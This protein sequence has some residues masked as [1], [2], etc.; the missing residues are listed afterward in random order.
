MKTSS[1]MK[2]KLQ[3]STYGV[4]FLGAFLKPHRRYICNHSLKRIV[5][6]AK[7]DYNNI[8]ETYSRVN[9]YLGILSHY[10]SYRIRCNLFLTKFFLKISYY[11]PD[12]KKMIKPYILGEELVN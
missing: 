10:S 7:F 5:T 4:E 2:L 8:E 9:S 11:T 1:R 3:K 12:M 6:K